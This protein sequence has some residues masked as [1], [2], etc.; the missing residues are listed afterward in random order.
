MEPWGRH[1]A[2]GKDV[3]CWGRLLIWERPIA[4]GKPVTTAFLL[5]FFAYLADYCRRVYMLTLSQW[6][7]LGQY[8]LLV[9]S[10][11]TGEMGM[12]IILL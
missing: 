11:H 6:P 12:G 8:M 2:D 4:H 7:R 9:T 1:S 3:S 5:E 10:V